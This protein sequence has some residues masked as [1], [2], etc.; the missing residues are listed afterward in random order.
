M[1]L[2]EGWRGNDA[3]LTRERPTRYSPESSCLIVD[4]DMVN[5]NERVQDI[6]T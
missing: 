2:H 5:R 1:A 4:D 3:S 6:S